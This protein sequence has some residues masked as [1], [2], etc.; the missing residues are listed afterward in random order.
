LAHGVILV[1]CSAANLGYVTKPG[2]F[3]TKGHDVNVCA[4]C[5]TVLRKALRL[6]QV[7]VLPCCFRSPSGLPS[8]LLFCIVG[9]S[10]TGRRR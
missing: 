9:L 6:D 10:C 8:R 7:G 1:G 4:I 2:E 3:P 5:D